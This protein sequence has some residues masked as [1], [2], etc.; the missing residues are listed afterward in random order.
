V[1]RTLKLTKGCWERSAGTDEQE[2]GVRKVRERRTTGLGAAVMNDLRRTDNRR[3]KRG[4]HG[5]CEDLAVATFAQDGEDQGSKGRKQDSRE[6]EDIWGT[7]KIRKLIGSK[8]T[9][10]KQ[11]R[12]ANQLLHVNLSI[13]TISQ[14][15]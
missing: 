10:K 1:I 6:L 11:T 7:P 4:G 3:M 12:K 14:T 9:K 5:W 13:G 2:R 8:R 15:N